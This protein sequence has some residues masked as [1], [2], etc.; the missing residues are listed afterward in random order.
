M[1]LAEFD[2]W[3]NA[4]Y[5]A[6]VAPSVFCLF[7]QKQIIHRQYFFNQAEAVLIVFHAKSGE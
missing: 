4:D 7:L 6:I 3:A 1:G 2:V 5:E